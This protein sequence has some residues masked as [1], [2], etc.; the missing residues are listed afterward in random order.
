MSTKRLWIAGA[1]V[2]TLAGAALAGKAEACWGCNPAWAP[3]DPA[4][5]AQAVEIRQKYADEFTTLAAKMRTTA[6]DLDEA[7]AAGQADRAE[8]LRQ[9][10][11]DLEKEY[12]GLR[13]KAWAELERAGVAGAWMPG[14]WACRW[15]DGHRGMGR[16]RWPGGWA[17]PG[18]AT[19]RATAGRP[20]RPEAPRSLL[21]GKGAL[22]FRTGRSRLRGCPARGVG[23]ARQRGAQRVGEAP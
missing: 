20:G 2:V 16:G 6:R 13:A 18:A 23:Y 11:Y 5:Q 14:P 21:P 7:L 4:V 19:S 22:P 12:A 10:L 15:H 9:E 3:T 17:A 1:L 8:E